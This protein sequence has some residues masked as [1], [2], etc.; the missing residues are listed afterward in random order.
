MQPE[1]SRPRRL[2][3]AS[4]GVSESPSQDRV[5]RVL[6]L[7]WLTAEENAQR[8]TMDGRLE[9]V[10]NQEGVSA[11]LTVELSGLADAV[12]DTERWVLDAHTLLRRSRTRL[13]TE[14]EWTSLG[15]LVQALRVGLPR[16]RILL[17]DRLEQSAQ[18][19]ALPP[20]VES[21]SQEMQQRLDS[22]H[23]FLGSDD[24]GWNAAVRFVEA[25]L[26]I[27]APN[28]VSMMTNVEVQSR[29][30]PGRALGSCFVK[31]YPG[32]GLGDPF[33][34]D[35]YLHVSEL[36][37]TV[38]K[39][40]MN[41]TLYWGLRHAIVEAEELDG[42][43]LAVLPDDE[44][45]T[46]VGEFIHG[47]GTGESAG[48]TRAQQIS[49][50]CDDIR[51]STVWAANDAITIRMGACRHMARESAVAALVADRA[52]LR[53]AIEGDVVDLRLSAITLLTREDYL[54]WCTQCRAFAELG[55][56]SPV[57]LQVCNP[58]GEGAVETVLANIQVRQFVLA[59]GD[60]TLQ[61]WA[62]R[63]S[64]EEV[65]ILLGPSH[66]P[67]LG[68]DIKASLDAKAARLA[69]ISDRF[70]AM[71][72]DHSRLVQKR[73]ANH[74][75]ARESQIRI[76]ELQEQR[77]Q[78]EKRAR[79][80]RD[81]GKQ[82]KAMWIEAGGMPQGSQ[83]HRKAAARLALAGRLMRETPVLI[84]MRGRDFTRQLDP[85]IN[86]LAT[87]ADNL[88]GHLPLVEEQMDT[89]GEARSAFR[90]Q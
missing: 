69:R 68:G 31:A 23:R 47:E 25:R 64:D 63:V 84:C 70:V 14:H 18:G 46:L 57:E 39:N 43:L 78:V 81:I 2:S 20:E 60:E 40:A 67:D 61:S 41:K 79:A 80:L 15:S 76:L 8:V 75:D 65:G 86:F 12:F 26:P 6:G 74:P 9:Q 58:D 55:D 24:V 16:D 10:R 49:S 56:E 37:Q 36:A 27:P 51:E 50:R 11:R 33:T 73:A 35:R 77:S 3:S 59:A 54:G 53:R 44:L 5:F 19:G 42:S 71:D 21:L 30:V 38:L 88:H 66:A 13:L 48:R 7:P 17:Q 85:E 89:W 87:V 90:P 32:D 62:I 72:Q 82:L 83:A 4:P 45:Q 29:V 1:A 34:A 22:A 28:R 52:K